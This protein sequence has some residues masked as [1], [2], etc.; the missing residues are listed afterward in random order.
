MVL[1]KASLFLFFIIGT[2]MLPRGSSSRQVHSPYSPDL[3]NQGLQLLAKRFEDQAP[4]NQEQ[5]SYASIT[6]QFAND[7]DNKHIG[8]NVSLGSNTVQKHN[9]FTGSYQSSR[10]NVVRTYGSQTNQG[11]NSYNFAHV[12][13][14]MNVGSNTFQENN[15]F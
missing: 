9:Y 14:E 2:S 15:K 12:G 1:G 4:Q 5:I 3:I 6:N 8:G 11:F 7:F 10:P 13:G